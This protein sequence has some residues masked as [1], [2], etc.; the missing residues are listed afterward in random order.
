MTPS[1]KRFRHLIPFLAGLVALVLMPALPRAQA[2]SAADSQKEQTAMKAPS[3]SGLFESAVFN[4][5][6]ADVDH[7]RDVLE[8]IRSPLGG[9]IRA[10]SQMKVIVVSGVKEMVDACGAAIK[11]LDVPPVPAKHVDLAIYIIR[12]SKASGPSECPPN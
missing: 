12:A 6:Y 10:D 9:S 3:S 1:K 11:N 4:V 2:P 8:A 5:R 7:I